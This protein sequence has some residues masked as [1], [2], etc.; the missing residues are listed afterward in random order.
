MVAIWSLALLATTFL[1]T[2][3]AVPRGSIQVLNGTNTYVSQPHP[4]GLYRHN[5]KAILLVTDIFGYATEN[6]QNLADDF[7]KQGYLVV[8]PDLFDGD[9]WNNTR[10]FSQLFEWA[11]QFGVERTDPLLTGVIGAVQEK[12]SMCSS[13]SLNDRQS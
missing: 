7:A 13:F 4:P 10:D 5:L 12:Y 11:A 6:A 8:M 1:S 2:A 9:A 3:F